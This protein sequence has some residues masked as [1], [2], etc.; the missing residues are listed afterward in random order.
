[1]V[2]VHNHGSQVATDAV[3][4]VVNGYCKNSIPFNT[5]KACKGTTLSFLSSQPGASVAFS[6]APLLLK[7]NYRARYTANRYDRNRQFHVYLRDWTRIRHHRR[8]M[9]GNILGD[10][11]E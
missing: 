11:G 10:N 4:T 9:Y 2:T 6:R 5:T 7:R 8:W 3:T 1:M